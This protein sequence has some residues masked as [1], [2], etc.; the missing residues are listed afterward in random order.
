M[1]DRD[2]RAGELEFKVRL[3]ADDSGM[4]ADLKGLFAAKDVRTMIFEESLVNFEHDFD[5][6]DLK[7]WRLGCGAGLGLSCHR[8]RIVRYSGLC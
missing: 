4:V 3:L 5:V 8:S 2:G 1:S 6:N 7:S